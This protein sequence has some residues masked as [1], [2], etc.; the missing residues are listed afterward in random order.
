MRNDLGEVERIVYIVLSYR[1]C[2]VTATAVFVRMQVHLLRLQNQSGSL[3]SENLIWN[4]TRMC[5]LRLSWAND[6]LR[7]R[8]GSSDRNLDALEPILE[9]LEEFAA[10][11][12]RRLFDDELVW[13][14]TIGWHATCYYIYNCENDN[15]PSLREKWLD[16]SLYESLG[17]LWDRHLTV[18]AQRRNITEATLLAHIRDTKQKF[19]EAER[20]ACTIP[21]GPDR[22]G[23]I[24]H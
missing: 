16:A 9:F 24:G 5:S 12:K 19:L 15:I 2:G 8:L 17:I 3:I 1:N 6:E 11:H 21:E 7:N 23:T 18:E 20:T 13:D 10:F 22:A 4:S 14:S